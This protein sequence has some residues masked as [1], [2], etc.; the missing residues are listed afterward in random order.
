MPIFE[1]VS[2]SQ[3][4]DEVKEAY[5]AIKD[6]YGGVVPELVSAVNGCDYCINAHR[7]GLQQHDLDDEA[8][9]EILAVRDEGRRPCHHVGEL[10]DQRADCAPSAVCSRSPDRAL[11][12]WQSVSLLTARRVQGGGR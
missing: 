1:P 12:P 10:V 7:M 2:E 6:N 5:A 4:S 11:L 8:I 9:A 3:A